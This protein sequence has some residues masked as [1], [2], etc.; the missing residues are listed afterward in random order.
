MTLVE[1]ALVA[2]NAC[3]QGPIS[4]PIN[5]GSIRIELEVLAQNMVAATH[6]THANDGSGRLF[7]VDQA[8]EVILVNN[9]AQ[10]A[11]PYLDLSGLL[12][13]LG[14]IIPPFGNPFSDYDERGFLGMAFHPNFAIS[15]QNGFGRFYTYTSEASNGAADFTVP[16]PAGEQFNHQSVIREWTVDPTSNVVTGASSRE[17]MRIDQPQFNHNGGAVEFGGDGKLYV[18]LGDGG[19]A[20]DQGSGH[21]TTTGNGQDLSNVLGSILRI[22]PLGSNSANGQYGV[23]GD[24]PFVGQSGKVGEIFAYGFRNPYRIGFDEPTFG[25][26][27]ADVGQNNIEEVDI[28]GSGDNLG[29]RYKEGSFYYDPST[30]TVS[31]SPIPGVTPNGFTS[32]DPV[33]EYDH[34]E[35]ISIIGGYVYRGSLV[36]QLQ[37]KYQRQFFHA[38]WTAVLRRPSDWPNQGVDYRL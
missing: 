14:G 32:V 1:V 31:S 15:G 30:N 34:D 37:G 22:D 8:G 13:P 7:I 3:S 12:V 27:V 5:Q 36:P 19:A 35:G 11:T 17:I 21:N 29:W 16:L 10:Q 18:A 28:V 23:P 26:I 33:L 38:E 6:L 20:R 2:S 4:P 24:N 9:G 25:L